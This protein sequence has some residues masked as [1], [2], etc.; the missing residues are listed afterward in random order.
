MW[1]IYCS[2]SCYQFGSVSERFS[3][4]RAGLAAGDDIELQ[5]RVGC[6]HVS[7]FETE[8]F[9]HDIAALSDGAGLVESDFARAALAAEAAVA[10][11]DEL[12]GRDVLERLANF[13]GDIFGAVGLE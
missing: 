5:L 9:A 7:R 13:G 8:L 12:V 2:R 11:D 6:G 4:G 1:N 3:S 10:R